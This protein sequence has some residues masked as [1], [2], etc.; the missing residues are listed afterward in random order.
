MIF[1]I[2]QAQG[3]G[4][5][6][7]LQSALNEKDEKIKKLKILAVKTKKELTELNEKVCSIYYLISIRRIE[8]EK[9]DVI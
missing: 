9:N 8:I 7:D 4:N 6:S 5:L 3:Q 2:F 1:V